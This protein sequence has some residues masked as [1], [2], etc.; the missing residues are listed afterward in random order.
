[1]HG[2]GEM[3]WSNGTVF[4]GLSIKYTFIGKFCDGVRDGFGKMSMDNS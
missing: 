4:K 2:Q 3:K 1:M